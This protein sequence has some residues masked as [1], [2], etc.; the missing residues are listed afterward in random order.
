MDN[1]V[2]ETNFVEIGTPKRGKVRDIYDL[3]ESLLIVA[4]DRISAF[5]VV[6]PG[7]IEDK[8]KVLNK[9]SIFWFKQME[10]FIGNHILEVDANRYPEPLRQYRDVLSG[11]SMI[12]KKA[13]PM[14][15]ECVVRGYLAGSGWKEYQERGSSCGIALPEGLKESSKLEKPI[16]TPTTKADEGHDMNMTFEE[17]TSSLGKDRAAQLRDMSIR[18]Y[19][20]ACNIAE[21]KGIIIADTKFEFG[22]LNDE[23]ILIDEVL[24]PDSSRFWSM[25]AYKPGF[26]QDSYDKQIVRDYLNTLD[27]DKTYPGPSLPEDVAQKARARY[28]EILTILTGEGL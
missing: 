20:N 28:I 12:V 23:M 19:E 22:T 11:R 1:V 10:P 13:K 2:R 24:T 27:W 21:K 4:S 9:L 8:G 17:L 26:S 14:S 25:K 6:L 16:F 3:G 18:I 7:G 15:A 5:D